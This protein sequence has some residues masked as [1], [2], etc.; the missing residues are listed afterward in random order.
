MIIVYRLSRRNDMISLKINLILI[1]V[2][3]CEI[4]ILQSYVI[5]ITSLRISLNLFSD[6]RAE[7]TNSRKNVYLI[8]KFQW[9]LKLNLIN[10]FKLVFENWRINFCT[11]IIFWIFLN[12]SSDRLTFVHS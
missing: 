5:S 2:C 4:Q 11:E 8:K 6:S 7:S 1:C 9:N 12:F 10:F 3:L